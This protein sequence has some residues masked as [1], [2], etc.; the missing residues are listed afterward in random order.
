MKTCVL[1]LLFLS[2]SIFAAEPRHKQIE[3]GPF[4]TATIDSAWPRGNIS[5]KGVA[6]RL[7]ENGKDVG[8]VLYDTDLVRVAS[9]WQGGFLNFTKDVM[10]ARDYRSILPVS[11]PI[12]ATGQLPGWG[13]PADGSFA[14]PRERPF[15]PLPREWAKYRGLY[16]SG[17]KSVVFYTSGQA[18][19]LEL[20]QAERVGDELFVTRTLDIKNISKELKTLLCD[21]P[22]TVGTILENGTVAFLEPE[23][24]DK[25][26]KAGSVSVVIDRAP[27]NGNWLSMGFASRGDYGNK[28]KG[29]V[30]S[31]DPKLSKVDPG[32]GA[33][34]SVLS[35]LQDGN[36]GQ[37][38]MDGGRVV[39]FKSDTAVIYY[40]LAKPI[41]VRMIET[42]S[43]HRT[44]N[45]SQK[46]TVFGSNED[47]RPAADS[48][49]WQQIA[50]VDTSSLDQGGIHGV[51]I[52]RENGNIGKYKFLM[53]KVEK[54]KGNP[55][56][57]TEI[58]VHAST[59][60]PK[61]K[62]MDSETVY[63]VA[64]VNAGSG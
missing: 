3:Y 23:V 60:K 43:W 19:I 28:K 15:G 33:Q 38:D 46:Y 62:K 26:A 47:K 25:N 22:G 32:A 9:A 40:D 52:S 59:D 51:T 49:K 13:N 35:R 6:I 31:Y 63:A 64:L 5:Y 44:T 17:D 8:G 18:E 37:H 55:T 20:P 57:Y 54:V 27:S 45:S 39:S 2:A 41:D 58:D 56:W 53:F 50:K 10:S 14:D 34:K 42:F 7:T 16:I 61:F 4:V 36:G 48:D 29:V 1:L 11:E 12:V 21:R 30:V 24:K